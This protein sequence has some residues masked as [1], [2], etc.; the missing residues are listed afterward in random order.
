MA[1]HYAFIGIS[2]GLVCGMA[3]IVHIQKKQ[4]M[5]VAYTSNSILMCAVYSGFST[6]GWLL[7]ALLCVSK[8]L[9]KW[10]QKCW[11][12]WGLPQKGRF[13]C[14]FLGINSTSLACW[15]VITTLFWDPTWVCW[16]D[17]GEGADLNPYKNNLCDQL[18]NIW[19][20]GVFIV[21]A[22]F[23]N[24]YLVVDEQ[25]TVQFSKGEDR[26]DVVN[27]QQTSPYD[28]A[29]AYHDE[30]ATDP[31]SMPIRVEVPD[32]KQGNLMHRIQTATEPRME[33]DRAE[34]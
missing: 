25:L 18:T 17:L 20:Y 16:I 33:T 21:L 14:W 19:F 31:E 27:M 7:P 8:S 11:D 34:L 24:L 5:G 4:E 30:M 15:C 26:E 13:W 23:V 28:A 32:A 3:T 22:I 29:I 1:C 9:D 12:T 2:C 10:N 6:I